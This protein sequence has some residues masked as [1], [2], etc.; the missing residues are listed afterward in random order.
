MLRTIRPSAKFRL[1]SYNL[2][3]TEFTGKLFFKHYMS[4]VI[5]QQV[6]MTRR[7]SS[8]TFGTSYEVGLLA[9]IS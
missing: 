9:F 4:L 7:K 1:I 5:I 8:N 6:Y 2:D 3:G